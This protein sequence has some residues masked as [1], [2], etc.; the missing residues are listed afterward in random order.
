MERMFAIN[1]N[2]KRVGKVSCRVNNMLLKINT[3]QTWM[4]VLFLAD[5]ELEKEPRLEDEEIKIKVSQSSATQDF[6]VTGSQSVRDA[7]DFDS[8][9]K[10][11]SF[12]IMRTT[13]E[14][15]T[16]GDPKMKKKSIVDALMGNRLQF[17][18]RRMRHNMN[19]NN[20]YT[21]VFIECQ[22]Q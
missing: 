10:Y 16:E 11:V 22:F 19:G 17:P 3:Q 14:H 6:C 7:L 4:D 20:L 5:P 2:E 8:S 18:H 1:I 15:D 13:I 21:I 9:L 12:T